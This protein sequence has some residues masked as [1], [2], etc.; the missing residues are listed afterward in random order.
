VPL[1]DGITWLRLAGLLACI[2]LP[3][4]TDRDIHEYMDNSM[5]D[6]I[7]SNRYAVSE[8]CADCRTALLHVL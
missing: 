3:D 7:H 2:V 4:R 1:P 6:C 5:A 8:C